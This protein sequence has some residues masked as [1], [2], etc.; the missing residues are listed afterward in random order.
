LHFQKA[1]KLILPGG[2]VQAYN[3]FRELDHLKAQIET[4][5]S[6]AKVQAI[7]DAE[8]RA[9]TNTE[10]ESIREKE[11]KLFTENEIIYNGSR[12]FS[13]VEA[14]KFN[15]NIH[16]LDNTVILN[17]SIGNGFA[18][19][20]I[21]GTVRRCKVVVGK[22]NH[23]TSNLSIH[24]YAGGGRSPENSQ[25][26]IGDDNI[27]NGNVS[28]IGG[29][30]NDTVVSIGNE[31]LFADNINISGAVDHLI[32]DVNT[33]EKLSQEVGVM[34]EDRIWVCSEA[35]ILNKSQVSSDT[36]V[37]ARA[38]VNKEFKQNNVLISGVPARVVRSN[39][40]WHLHTTDDYL[41]NSS[42]LMLQR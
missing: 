36:I 39:V 2:L 19:I 10:A 9:K 42:P 13:N 31:N 25:I 12:I 17:E 18:H 23:I 21:Q 7:L 34:L 29:T 15:L 33:K 30:H 38:L 24:F 40:M 20:S 4:Y 27:F 16:G 1:L 35:R 3:N 14:P 5:Q 37:A 6:T 41:S 8:M 11:K 22:R 32:Y 28:I 26:T